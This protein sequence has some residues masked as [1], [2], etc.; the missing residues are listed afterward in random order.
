M[1]T[2]CRIINRIINSLQC[3]HM[4]RFVDINRYQIWRFV[5]TRKKSKLINN[6][7]NKYT[8][9]ALGFDTG[10]S[11]I[12]K[13]S[14]VGSKFI[15]SIEQSNAGILYHVPK[16]SIS[17]LELSISSLESNVIID[18]LKLTHA[19]PLKVCISPRLFQW[20]NTDNKFNEISLGPE[21]VN[22]ARNSWSYRWCLLSVNWTLDLQADLLMLANCFQAT[23]W[24]LP[25]KY[26]SCITLTGFPM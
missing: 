10:N 20:L 22:I 19:S 3:K 12:K 15:F 2:L 8:S 17:S 23:K 9:K 5:N 26:H 18:K 1:Y 6:V 24:I 13:P 21:Y 4:K 14:L 7:I 16:L 11:T 25:W